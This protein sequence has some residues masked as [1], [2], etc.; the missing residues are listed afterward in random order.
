MQ[1]KSVTAT[2]CERDGSDKSQETRRRCDSSTEINVKGVASSGKKMK[3]AG[4]EPSLPEF[5][6]F[7]IILPF[8]EL[9]AIPLVTR[10]VAY[11]KL[12]KLRSKMKIT[13]RLNSD[14][15]VHSGSAW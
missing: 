4:K 11:S 14:V 13:R 9:R 8:L 2:D 15:I 10:A 1:H 5:V 7:D 6:F 12:M 3:L